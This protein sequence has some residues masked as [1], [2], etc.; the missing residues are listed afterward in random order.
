MASKFDRF[1]FSWLQS[2]GNISK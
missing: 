2:V 1:E